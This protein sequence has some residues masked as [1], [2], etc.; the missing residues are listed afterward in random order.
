[1]SNLVYYQDSGR[2]RQKIFTIFLFVTFAFPKAGM[3]IYGIPV[4]I[5]TILYALSLLILI[6]CILYYVQQNIAIVKYYIVYCIFV[7]LNTVLHIGR[8]P[9][10]YYLF[11]VVVAFSPLAYLIGRNI[12][13][14]LC[15]KVLCLAG[16]ITGL[17]S[18]AQWLFG[19]TQ[20]TIPGITLALG[21][22][23]EDKPIGYGFTTLHEATKMPSTAQ[24]GNNIAI[25]CVLAIGTLL[26]WIPNTKKW[27]YAKWCSLGLFFTALIL[28][29]ARSSVYPF[30]CLLP[31]GVYGCWKQYHKRGKKEWIAI[32][33]TLAVT[34][35]F[36]LILMQIP[37]LTPL[38]NQETA[39]DYID[40]PSR[41]TE[42][43]GTASGRFNIWNG[44][45]Q[46]LKDEYSFLDWTRLIF[47]GAS[48]E[49]MMMGGEG[50]P[51]F[52]S[53]FGAL[54]AV[55]FMGMFIPILMLFK[56]TP[57]FIWATLSFAGALAVDSGYNYPPI[58]IWFFV[59]AGVMM[60]NY[61]EKDNI[62]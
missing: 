30:F 17:Y 40:G 61:K 58:L 19:I 34:A 24:N 8:L 23:W 11:A 54:S 36:I 52:I 20:T 26:T 51:L 13:Y 55:L 62:K 18:V 9:L 3:L 21:D 6:P 27:F 56:Q 50:L 35:L 16:I 57:T 39:I 59:L 33:L 15:M 42:D 14:E 4:T 22:S 46:T 29:G 2:W 28:S 47:I 1:M 5:S 41:L 43:I 10:K 32:I 49:N 48:G 7:L 25:L 12:K 44:M 53:M 38:V 45:I 37:Q 60:A 31:L